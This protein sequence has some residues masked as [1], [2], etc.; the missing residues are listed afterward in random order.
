MSD[1]V[2]DAITTSGDCGNILY[3][4]KSNDTSAGTGFLKITT[5]LNS[6]GIRIYTEDDGKIGEFIIT[7]TATMEKYPEKTISFE[8]PIEI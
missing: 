7:I 6:K 8:M 1:T 5:L 4:L 3:T 2:T